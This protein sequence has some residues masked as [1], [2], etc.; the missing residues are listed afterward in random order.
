MSHDSPVRGN[1]SLL[2]RSVFWV[3]SFGVMATMGCSDDKSVDAG[4]VTPPDRVADLVATVIEPDSAALSWS[5]P[6]DNGLDGRASYFEL[7]RS[8]SPID[9]STWEAATLVRTGLPKAPGQRDTVVIGG[10]NVGESFFRLRVADEV[11]NW[12]PLSNQVS[13]LIEEPPVPLPVADLRIATVTE[14]I[15]ELAWTAPEIIG[16]HGTYDLRY[17]SA[18]LTEETWTAAEPVDGL[19]TPATPGSEER[20]VINDLDSGSDYYFGMKVA[21]GSEGSSDL[22]NTVGVT[23]LEVRRLTTSTHR[24]GANNPEWSPDGTRIVM[25]ADFHT[26]EGGFPTIFTVP[27][28]GGEPVRFTSVPFALSPSWSSLSDEIAFT[29]EADG[30]PIGR[31]RELSVVDAYPA[32]TPRVVVNHDPYH[33]GD[34]VWSP[35][36]REIAYEVLID[37]FPRSAELWVLDVATAERRRVVEATRNPIFASW[38]PESDRLI[39]SASDGSAQDL[40]TLDLGSGVEERVTDTPSINEVF[41]AWSP[42]GRRI[43]FAS[44]EAGTIDIWIM[45][46]TG[47]NRIRVTTAPDIE[48]YPN[49]SPDGNELVYVIRE[50]GIRDLWVTTIPQ[51]SVGSSR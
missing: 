15:V 34:V 38:S 20:F 6:G 31:I 8:G 42:D 37:R 13:A 45:D 48:N 40:W 23:L 4:D 44:D 33:I 27:S 11:P 21:S 10:L 47:A 29:S 46:A 50:N 9:D 22:S 16:Q 49:W 41:P 7:R 43:A 51:I 14:S 3:L 2:A 18:P 36:G 19:P 30:G 17:S 28:G 24:I 25:E 39:Y 32:A 5:A 35:D 26:S 1:Q 12:S